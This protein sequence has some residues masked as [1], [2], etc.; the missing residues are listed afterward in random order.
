MDTDSDSSTM[1]LTTQFSSPPVAKK[2]RG[3]PSK[4]SSGKRQKNAIG[5]V[6]RKQ[7]GKVQA[8]NTLPN[9]KSHRML[10][11]RLQVRQEDASIKLVLLQAFTHSLP[12][13]DTTAGDNKDGMVVVGR[14]HLA[15]LVVATELANGAN[16]QAACE[17][18]AR[19]YSFHWQTIQRWWKAFKMDDEGASILLQQTTTARVACLFDSEGM[20]ERAREWVR[21]QTTSKK[22][23]PAQ[24][25]KKKKGGVLAM[26]CCDFQKWV[27]EVLLAD[28]L[29]AEKGNPPHAIITTHNLSLLCSA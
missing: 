10:S 5:R 18:S 21:E 14:R 12:K 2:R 7:S 9:L 19:Y 27:N 17:R 24:K 20:Q 13:Y 11:E 25:K 29:A 8:E 3:R 16:L 6:A 1:D 15:L 23:T 22:L 28:T 26:R 4:S